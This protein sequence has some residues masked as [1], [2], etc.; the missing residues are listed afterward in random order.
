MRV[1]A[2]SLIAFGSSL[3]ADAPPVGR[4]KCLG[5]LVLEPGGLGRR[6]VSVENSGG[7]QV[8]RT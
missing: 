4:R 6:I 7:N 3:A 2:D 1:Q 5:G 8:D